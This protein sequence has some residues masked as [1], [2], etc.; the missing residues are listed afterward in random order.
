MV[1]RE[2]GSIVF[3]LITLLSRLYLHNAISRSAADPSAN[4]RYFSTG[5]TETLPGD[6]D[7]ISNLSAYGDDYIIIIIIKNAGLV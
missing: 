2:Y 7:K 5:V 1:F 6:L 3:I 4:P